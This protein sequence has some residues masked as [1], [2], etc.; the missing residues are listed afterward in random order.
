M[1]IYGG[2]ALRVDV[3]SLDA[4]SMAFTVPC[5]SSA[6]VT[7]TLRIISELNVALSARPLAAGFSVLEISQR[8]NSTSTADK[9]MLV[10]NTQEAILCA[11]GFLTLSLPDTL[12]L[13]L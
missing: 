2:L 11:E 8:S 1:R 12:P 13:F 4:P 9:P 7:I 10:E 5:I 6:G 3:G